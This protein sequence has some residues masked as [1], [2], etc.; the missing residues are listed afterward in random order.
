MPSPLFSPACYNV[1]G[2]VNG[3]DLHLTFPSP[4]MDCA[5]AFMYSF[6]SRLLAAPFAL[7]LHVDSTHLDRHAVC[8]E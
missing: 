3:T 8:N 1:D 5:P 2:C 6:K 7:K 4:P